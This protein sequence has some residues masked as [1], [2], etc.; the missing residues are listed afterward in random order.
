MEETFF[1]GVKIEQ[2]ELSTGVRIGLPVRYYDWAAIMA[3]FP[4]P[5]A[6][7]RKLLPTNKLKPAQLFPGTAIV[8]MVAMEYRRIADV[9][10]YNE[11]GIMV[12]VLYEPT[13]NI[14]GL[15]M[16]FPHWFKRFGLY[17]HHL[18]VTTQA[19]Y[20]FGVEIWG[21]PKIVAEIIFEDVGQ[22]RRCRLRAE[23][24]DIVTLEVG[25][26]ATRARPMNYYSYTVK[27]GQL[28]RTL[29][30]TQGQF[31]IARFRGGA[32]YTLGDHPIAEELRTLGMG[33]TAVERLW[34]PQMHSM[35]HP[36]GERL[37]L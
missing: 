12:P 7:V 23:G 31:G 18:P 27:D 24:K 34:A 26:L 25:K 30:Q 16:L 37:S 35:L 3:H 4:A 28:L 15:P 9:A 2:V 19:A 32:S 6:A 5:A 22:V 33:K 20:D 8:S 11:F 29:I 13:V 10:P 36:A 14:P 1:A 17:I 21:Y